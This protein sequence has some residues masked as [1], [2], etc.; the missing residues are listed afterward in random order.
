MRA[1]FPNRQIREIAIKT[2][3]RNA[4]FAHSENVLLAMLSDKHSVQNRTVAVRKI[5]SLSETNA[6][7][8]ATLLESLKYLKWILVPKLFVK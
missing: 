8:I 1:K 4:F 5:V 3:Q 6:Q 7:L 2:A